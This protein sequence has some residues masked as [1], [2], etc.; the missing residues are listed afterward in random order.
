MG[1][2]AEDML[3]THMRSGGR[4]GHRKPSGKRLLKPVE[5]PDCGWWF[6]G[7]SGVMQHQNAKH[8]CDWTRAQIAEAFASDE[9]EET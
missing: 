6:R 8:G 2:Y 5:C 1:D 9:F 4:V 7:K 3:R